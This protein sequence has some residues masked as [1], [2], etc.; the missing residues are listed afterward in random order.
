MQIFRATYDTCDGVVV[1]PFE[2]EEKKQTY[3]VLAQFPFSIRKDEIG[4]V[5][6]GRL[7]GYGLSKEEA[8]RVLR[9]S[10]ENMEE[11]YRRKADIFRKVANLAKEV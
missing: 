10:A 3:K 9:R 8:V 11:H 6:F 5:F 2:V 1:E 4:H 7:I